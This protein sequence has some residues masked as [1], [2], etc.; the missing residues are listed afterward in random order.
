MKLGRLVAA[1]RDKHRHARAVLGNV[2]QRALLLYYF[3]G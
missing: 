1:E 2:K 3:M